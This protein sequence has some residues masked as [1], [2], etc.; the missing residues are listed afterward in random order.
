MAMITVSASSMVV[1]AGSKDGLKRL[2]S[3]K[4]RVQRTSSIPFTLPLA[5]IFFGPQDGWSTPPSSNNCS[6]SESKAGISAR[7]SRQA[8]CI[9]VGRPRG[10]IPRGRYKLIVRRFVLFPS[11]IVRFS[12]FPF[13]ENG[14]PMIAPASLPKYPVKSQIITSTFDRTFVLLCHGGYGKLGGIDFAQLAF[15]FRPVCRSGSRWEPSNDG[16][17]GVLRVIFAVL[18]AG[19]GRQ[20]ISFLST[21]AS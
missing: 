12:N 15:Q 16:K 3:S 9:S 19:P 13:F 8:I 6:I 5:T 11:L 1:T 21:K 7:D 20:V 4:T 10:F 18:T 14:P 17:R 2:A